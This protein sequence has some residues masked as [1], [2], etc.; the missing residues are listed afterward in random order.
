MNTARYAILAFGIVLLLF[1]LTA[2]FYVS[3]TGTLPIVEISLKQPPPP[4]PISPEGGQLTIKNPRKNP[5]SST[6]DTL[7]L[8]YEWNNLEK[9]VV[10][11]MIEQELFKE[12][13]KHYMTVSTLDADGRPVS[14]HL[15]LP[16]TFLA[17]K[18]PQGFF[19][20]VLEWRE[21]SPEEVA[22]YLAKDTQVVAHINTTYEATQLLNGGEEIG[23]V[24]RIIIPVP[25]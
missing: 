25:E 4:A 5:A 11:G 20:K 23:P 14:F 16:D 12:G 7:P 10:S 13:V 8:S 19:G 24:T 22:P 18:L 6:D 15:F 1:L 3:K 17:L 2:G 21:T 9:L